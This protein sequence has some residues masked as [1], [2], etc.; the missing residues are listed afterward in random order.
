MPKITHRE[1]TLGNL[2]KF[3]PVRNLWLVQ[4]ATL[5]SKLFNLSKGLILNAS[6]ASESL[7]HE[8][9]QEVSCTCL[10]AVAACNSVDFRVKYSITTYVP[11]H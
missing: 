10:H 4:Y 9:F 3:R 11:L 5:R 7:Q 2:L 8:H 1:S 6:L